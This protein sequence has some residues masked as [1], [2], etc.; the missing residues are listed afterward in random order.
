MDLVQTCRW[1]GKTTVVKVSQVALDMYKAGAFITEAFP[2]KNAAEREVIMTGMC[3]DCQ[4][5]T[6]HR[7]APGHEKEWGEEVGECACC[8]VSLYD[9]HDNVPMSGRF[10]CPACHAPLVRTDA[11]Y[12]DECDDEEE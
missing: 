3:Y 10:R 9:K 2:K 5:K 6:F 12:I 11:G 7:P 8:G 4:E 1:C